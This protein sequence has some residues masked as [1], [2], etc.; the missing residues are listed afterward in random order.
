V[1][2]CSK[3]GNV[4]ATPQRHRRL[5]GEAVRA[6][7]KQAEFSQEQLAEKADLST[8]FISGIERGVESPLVEHSLNAHLFCVGKP[9]L[10]SVGRQTQR[11]P[12]GLNGTFTPT[13]PG[14]NLSIGGSAEQLIFLASP[15][16]IQGVGWAWCDAQRYPPPVYVG[17]TALE[18]FRDLPVAPGSKQFFFFGSPWLGM[19][20]DEI[21]QFPPFA[22]HAQQRVAC[23]PRDFTVSDLAEHF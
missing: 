19:G 4:M 12:P 20:A 5:L 22:P 14:C 3:E 7:R 23:T 6:A 11:Q 15:E 8:V 1:L 9:T 18:N 21:S 17:F 2:T 16:I 13:Y 10:F